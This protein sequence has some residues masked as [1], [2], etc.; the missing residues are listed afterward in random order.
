MQANTAKRQAATVGSR[1]HRGEMGQ[2]FAN[3]KH[4]AKDAREMPSLIAVLDASC[5]AFIARKEIVRRT[6]PPGT[7][8]HLAIAL[9][10][11]ATKTDKSVCF[12]TL[13]DMRPTERSAL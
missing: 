3:E 9:G 12:G 13:A 4:T 8:P 11:E 1:K 6:D 10:V 5:F 2:N 7:R